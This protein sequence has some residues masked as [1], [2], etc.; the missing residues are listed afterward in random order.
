MCATIL[1]LQNFITLLLFAIGLCSRYSPNT[2]RFFVCFIFVCCV[3]SVDGNFGELILTR[4]SFHYSYNYNYSPY[5][6]YGERFL[7]FVHFMA[8][9]SVYTVHFDDYINKCSTH[10]F[11]CLSALICLSPSSLSFVRFPALMD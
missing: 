4:F 9:P 2:G 1:A 7:L 10:H 6:V 8:L 5:C 11:V 3:S